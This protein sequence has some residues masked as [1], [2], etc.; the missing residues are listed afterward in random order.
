METAIKQSHQQQGSFRTG[1]FVAIQVRGLKRHARFCSRARARGVGR[2]RRL[3]GRE[4]RTAAKQKAPRRQLARRLT[5]ERV[6]VC[7][8]LCIFRWLLWKSAHMCQ[9]TAASCVRAGQSAYLL[10]NQTLPCVLCGHCYRP[11]Q[12]TLAQTKAHTRWPLGDICMGTR[13]ASQGL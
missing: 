4:R 11:I 10:A 6:C 2:R 9:T 7:V 8:C 3:N 5:I 1:I 13:V 12:N